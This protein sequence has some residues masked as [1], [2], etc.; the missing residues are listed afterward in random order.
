MALQARKWQL[1]INN[2][3]EKGISREDLKA[4]I[5]KMKSTVYWCMSE[6]KGLETGTHHIHIFVQLRSPARFERL[7]KLF[8][9]AHIENAYGTAQANKEYVAKTGKWA[10]DPKADTAIPDTFEEGGEMQED[11][12]PQGNSIMS[13]IY[14][15]VKAGMSNVEIME[16]DPRTAGHID[17]MDKIR[18]SILED[19][20]RT[21][22]RKLDVTYIF[23][24]TGTGKTMSVM[25]MS[26]RTKVY[27]ITDY[28]HPFDRYAQEEILLFDEFRSSLPL[29]DMLVYLEGYPL[30]LPARYANRQACYNEVFIVSNIDLSKQYPEVQQFEPESYRAF[31]RRIHKVI[32]YKADFTTVDHGAALDYIFPPA[33]EWVK[34]AEQLPVTPLGDLDKSPKEKEEKEG[35]KCNE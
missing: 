21:E 4:A 27:R 28:N 17:T 29:K 20:C 5:G 10:D 30:A 1:T 25:T 14:T 33:P 6:E 19:R 7:K 9:E 34:E 18:L 31:L 8:P 35:R 13:F 2:P 11:T 24:A 16:L 22:Y 15:N 23:G 26:D 12:A 32:E 3:V